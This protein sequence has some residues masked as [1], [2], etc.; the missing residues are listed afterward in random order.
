MIRIKECHEPLVDIKKLCPELVIDIG[1]RRTKKEQKAY[2]RK[3]V[4]L[5]ICRAK[6]E[7]PKGMTFIIGDAWRPQYI[8]KEIKQG[9]IQRFSKKYPH[10]SK[11]RV[12]QEVNKFVAPSNGK[13]ASGH[14]TG[15]AVDLR[16]LRNGR[17]VPMKSAKLTYQENAKSFQPK[18][19]K[20]IQRNRELL[21]NVLSKVGLSNSLTEYWHWSY[22]DI[23][24]AR[25]TKKK[26][27]IYGVV[28]NIN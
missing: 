9:F 4:A 11:N 26:V 3:T 1:P 10:W 24:W 25:R 6:K 20:Y 28:K 18:L 7:L 27:A 13:Y 23:W 19:P 8:Q 12:L 15:G 14:M 5:M 21:F 2:L 17:K 22:G 16:L